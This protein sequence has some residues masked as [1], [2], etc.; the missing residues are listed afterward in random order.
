MVSTRA[1][2]QDRPTSQFHVIED[3]GAGLQ[4]VIAIDSLVLGPAA[5]GCRLWNY[6][7]TPE[8]HEDAMRPARGMTYKNAMAGLPFGGG[9]AVLRMPERPFS[10]KRLFEAFGRAVQRLQGQYVTAGDVGTGVENMQATRRS[11]RFVAGLEQ[12]DGRAGGDPS[13]W[14]ARG[15]FRSMA[16]AAELVLGAELPELRVAVQGAGSVGSQLCPLLARAGARVLVS[17][18]EPRRTA[19]LAQIKG[20]EVVSPE[21][22]HTIDADVFAPCALGGALTAATV[23]ELR[24]R[25]VCGAANNQVSG[26]GVLD[27]MV[28]TGI[29][30]VPDYVVNAGGII[31]VAAEYLGENQGRVEERIEAIAP[32]VKAILSRAQRERR[33]P[34]IVADEMVAGMLLPQRSLAA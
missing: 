3:A 6:S 26:E 12:R 1:T 22:I 5:G 18:V 13:P 4:G 30:Y 31:N 8:M 29:T 9:K 32:R 7:S 25:L 15:V 34:A 20:I 10:R 23:S 11:T 24:A 17:D 16:V 14:T 33:S 27:Q 21:A 28:A 2:A 19:S